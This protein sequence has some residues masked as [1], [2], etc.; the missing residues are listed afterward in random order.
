MVL[1]DTWLFGGTIAENIAYGADSFDLAA[2][3]RGG[4]GG[5][6]RPLRADAA[7]TATTR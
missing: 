5:A 1:Q 2:V 7:R 3:Q 4:R 6:R